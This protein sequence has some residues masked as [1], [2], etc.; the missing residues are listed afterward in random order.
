VKKS[1]KSRESLK[2]QRLRGLAAFVLPFLVVKE[3]WEKAGPERPASFFQKI[4]NDFQFFSK[5]HKI[6]F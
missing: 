4:F 5:A 1:G 6:R 2:N 3:K